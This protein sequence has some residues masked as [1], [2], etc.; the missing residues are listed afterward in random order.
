MDLEAAGRGSGGGLGTTDQRAVTEDEVDVADG[1]GVTV[2]EHRG[3]DAHTVDEG[4]V[5][6]AVVADLGARRVV[7]QGGVVTRGQHVGDDDVVVGRAADLDRTG[8]RVRRP[9]RPQDLEHA[10]REVAVAL[11]RGAA[12]GPITVTDSIAG[13]EMG[14]WT[15]TGRD[16]LWRGAG[17]ARGADPG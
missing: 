8:R 6:A 17:A 16:G 15:G 9:A 1:D 12:A 13:A 14:C 7:D 2:G 3:V 11:E 10:G 5:D 4:A